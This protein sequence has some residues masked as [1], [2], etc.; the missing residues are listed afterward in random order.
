[1]NLALAASDAPY[2]AVLNSDGRPQLG[3]LRALAHEL[4]ERPDAVWAAPAVHGPGEPDHQPGAPY[5]ETRL[6][7]MALLIRRVEFLEA[8]GF[9]PA[10]FFY[11]EDYDASHRLRAAGHKLIRVPGARFDHGKGGR[12]RRGELVRERHFARTAALLALAHAPS[13][14][15]ELP[16]LWRRRLA[17][18]A[19]HARSGSWPALAGI[20]LVTVE[21]PRMAAMAVGRCAPRPLAGDPP[22][23]RGAARALSTSRIPGWP[24]GASAVL[25]SARDA[26]LARGTGTSDTQPQFGP[27]RAEPTR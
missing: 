16:A 27:R 8:G 19:R 2:V 15:S 1:M 18:L 25:L 5:E 7:G 17:S 21:L 23:A 4:D 11:N 10:Y 3:M 6:S 12:S 24:D 22:R 14:R 26:S 9:D 13:F 20:A